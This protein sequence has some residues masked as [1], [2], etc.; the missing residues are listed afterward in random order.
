VVDKILV[1]TDDPQALAAARI[2]V[3]AIM[4]VRHRLRPD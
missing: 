2:D 4:R 1:K 3:E